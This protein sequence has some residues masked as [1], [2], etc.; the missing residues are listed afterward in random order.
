MLYF[1]RRIKNL[2][3]IQA[4]T[5]YSQ[6]RNNYFQAIKVAKREHWNRFLK[7]EDPQSIFKA[8]GYTKERQ[9]SQTPQIRDLLD[10]LQDSFEGKC[11]AFKSTLF[12][13]PLTTQPTT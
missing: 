7:Q 1:Q 13:S 6:A 8:L 12:P 5:L 4:T 9:V 11:S 3:E 10:Q 2:R